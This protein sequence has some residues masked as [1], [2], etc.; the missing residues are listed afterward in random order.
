MKKISNNK[1]LKK[2]GN[3]NKKRKDKYMT[4]SYFG[5]G[6]GKK[7]ATGRLPRGHDATD[8]LQLLEKYPVLLEGS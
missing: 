7:K 4:N 1:K 6:E 2:K 8:S 3:N 5:E